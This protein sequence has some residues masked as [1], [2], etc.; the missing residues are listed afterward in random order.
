LYNTVINTS[1]QAGQ[2]ARIPQQILQRCG[3]NFANN[4]HSGGAGSQQIEWGR[5]LAKQPLVDAGGF[6]ARSCWP[7]PKSSFSRRNMKELSVGEA[8]ATLE[9]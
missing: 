1:D 3:E 5:S 6:T 7:A 2:I 9:T 4:E 8:L